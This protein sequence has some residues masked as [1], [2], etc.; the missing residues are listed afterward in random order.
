MTNESLQAFITEHGNKIFCILLNNNRKVFL[1]VS[2]DPGNTVNATELI[3]ETIGGVD[4]F[5]IKHI[6]RTWGVNT[7]IP[8]TEWFVT[9]FIEGIFVTDELGTEIPD[10]NKIF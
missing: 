5:G 4:M 7:A 9:G 1:G 6:D 3:L 10:I 2:R 8:F